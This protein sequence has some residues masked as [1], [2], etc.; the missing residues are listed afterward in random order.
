MHDTLRIGANGKVVSEKQTC[1]LQF[2]ACASAVASRLVL[3]HSN[4]RSLAAIRI[5]TRHIAIASAKL[6]LI[7][8]R[9]RIIEYCDYYVSASRRIRL[10]AAHATTSSQAEPCPIVDA[11]ARS[12]LKNGSEHRPCCLFMRAL[13][14][15]AA[16]NG[17]RLRLIAHL[18]FALFDTN[19]GRPTVKIRPRLRGFLLATTVA[20]SA[21][22]VAYARPLI[23][24]GYSPV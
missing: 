8:T 16:E 1:R 2:W 13:N 18:G 3:D 5:V 7:T 9:V 12:G 11:T 20:L 17:E 19:R 21:T 23:R 14:A 15:G 24:M 6:D 4:E 22:R 10:V